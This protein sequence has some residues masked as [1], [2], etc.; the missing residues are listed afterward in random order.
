[1]E[2]AFDQEYFDL[3]AGAQDDA[4][5]GLEGADRAFEVV[6][7]AQFEVLAEADEARVDDHV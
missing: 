2:G 7:G 1:M 3:F 6:G 5:G 4:D